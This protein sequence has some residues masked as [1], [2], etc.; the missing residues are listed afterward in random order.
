[1]G[2]PRL[3]PAGPDSEAHHSHQGQWKKAFLRSKRI[4][5][6]WQKF[7]IDETFPDEIATRHRY[8]ARKKTWVND[9]V[10]IR[11]EEEVWFGSKL[12]LSNLQ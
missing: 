5:D 7:H 8:N 2:L 6:P 12:F 4:P 11:M 10:H 9:E 1:M 3:T